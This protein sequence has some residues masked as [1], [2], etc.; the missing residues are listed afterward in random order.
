[1]RF[2]K[3]LRLG[4][5]VA[6]VMGM[7]LLANSCKDDSKEDS[8]EKGVVAGVVSDNLGTPIVDVNVAVEGTSLKTVTAADGTYELADVP[9]KKSTVSFTKEGYATVTSTLQPTAFKDGKATID[10]VM[11]IAN[12]KITG[13]CL[14]ARNGNAPLA[15]VTVKLN[16]AESTTTDGEGV[17]LFEG[18]TIDDYTLVF[19]MANCVD[20]T[21]TVTKDQFTGDFVVT[22]EDIR[23]GGKEVLR[24]ATAEDLANVDVWHYNEYRGGKNGDD[25]PHFDWSTDFM[26]TFT[27]WYGWWEEQN[28]GTTLQI[29]N[30]EADGHWKNPADH[31]VFDSYLCGKKLIT[32]DNYLMSIKVRT[33]ACSEDSPA[34]WGVMVVDLSAAD[35]TAELVGEQQTNYNESYSNPDPSFDLSKWKGKEVVIAIGIYRWETGDYWK[36]LV[37]RRIDFSKTQPGEWDYLPGEA[38]P[39]LDAG[40]K[41]T[42]EMV[43]STMPVT[44]FS[45]FIGVSPDPAQDI[46]GPEKYRDAYKNW[47]KAGHFAAWWSCMPVHKDN[48]PFAGE[49][50]VIKTNGG[51]T[52]VSTTAPQ[53][54]FYAKFAIASGHNTIALKARNFSS[55]NATYFKLTAISE[56][57]TVK[58]I[59]PTATV[60]SAADNGCWK[61]IHE[62][63]GAD[64]PDAYAIFTYDLSEFNGKNVVV[65]LGVFK[66]EDNGDENK[67]AIY[68]ISIK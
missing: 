2:A 55:E 19:S 48:E 43:R 67:L 46:D 41:M 1:M 12:A 15:G 66:G 18:L 13:K 35:P 51:G 61:F 36:Q 50:F 16:G 59:T 44:E 40:Y 56:D 7:S 64:D 24:G 34:H 62:N 58:H 68:S 6:A 38:V 45:D 14:D 52:A 39:G 47:R 27:S 11:E 20:V 57:G 5:L 42:M 29:R 8:V 26:G 30:S 10:V 54:Y 17:Y 4:T 32:D 37:I 23:M 22:L 33:H 65:C 9:V 31:E 49:G 60:G 28:E 21:K 63:G 53:A 25:Y 3:I